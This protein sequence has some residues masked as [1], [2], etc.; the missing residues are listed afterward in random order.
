MLRRA[1]LALALIALAPAAAQE[2]EGNIV[3][4]A[5]AGTD[6]AIGRSEGLAVASL[7]AFE[8]G[9]FSSDPANPLRVDA[10]ALTALDPAKLAAAFQVSADN[11]LA[12]IDGRIELV[13]WERAA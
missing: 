11:P 5:A 13:S 6:L 10:A 9:L 3:T 2:I 7:H 1:G 12:G 4:G 8:A